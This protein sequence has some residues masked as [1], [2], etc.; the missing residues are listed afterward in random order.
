MLWIR[1]KYTEVYNSCWHV[2]EPVQNFLF[3]LSFFLNERVKN[4]NGVYRKIYWYHLHKWNE[5]W[6]P[7]C[8]ECERNRAWTYSER[9]LLIEILLSKRFVWS[10]KNYILWE[11]TTKTVHFNMERCLLLVELQRL[12]RCFLNTW[13]INSPSWKNF[14][15]YRSQ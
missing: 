4:E 14:P 1:L 8:Y 15:T 12:I 7:T 10:S 9:I 5:N 11:S 3:S 2:L 13:K 6:L